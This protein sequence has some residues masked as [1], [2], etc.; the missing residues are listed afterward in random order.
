LGRRAA[1]NGDWKKRTTAVFAREVKIWR[2]QKDVTQKGFQG[3]DVQ[4]G[5]SRPESHDF[6]QGE[7][8]ERERV[9]GRE[10]GSESAVCV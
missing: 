3:R 9:R 2:R 10:R 6:A 8:W 1:H 4:E 5:F 7:R